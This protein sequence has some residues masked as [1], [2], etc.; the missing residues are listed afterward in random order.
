MLLNI[1]A[2]NNLMTWLIICSVV[3]LVAC[4]LLLRVILL[5]KDMLPH[6]TAQTK[7]LSMMA[8]KQGVPVDEIEYVMYGINSVEKIRHA[9]N[10]K[11]NEQSAA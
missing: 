7:L 5:I 11:A 3:L 6:T 4:I 8:Y 2:P 9:K 1:S 10:K